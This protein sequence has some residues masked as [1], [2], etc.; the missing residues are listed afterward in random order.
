MLNRKWGIQKRNTNAIWGYVDYKEQQSQMDKIPGC[1]HLDDVSVEVKL[2]SN[3]SLA[4]WVVVVGDLEVGGV[5][6]LHTIIHLHLPN[7]SQQSGT[8]VLP[9]HHTSVRVI[10]DA[11][12]GSRPHSN[13]VCTLPC[14]RTADLKIPHESSWFHKKQMHTCN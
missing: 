7:C 13:I 2:S 12:G 11:V 8:F 6:V 9:C 4:L 1:A 14:K 3:L 10:K 5:E